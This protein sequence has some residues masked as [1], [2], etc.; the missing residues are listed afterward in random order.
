[1]AGQV[2]M[3]VLV[4]VVL[5]VLV[6]VL[7]VVLVLVLVLPLLVPLLLLLLLLLLT[8]MAGQPCCCLNTENTPVPPAQAIFLV[9]TDPLLSAVTVP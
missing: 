2:R 6:V 9:Y 7:V 8:L 1:M 4:V 5:L 3:L